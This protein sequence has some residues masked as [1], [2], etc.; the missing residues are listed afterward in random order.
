MK[1]LRDDVPF[2]RIELDAADAAEQ[3]VEC[4]EATAREF[5]ARARA[6]VRSVGNQS[7]RPALM[8][9]RTYIEEKFTEQGTL[10]AWGRTQIGIVDFLSKHLPDMPLDKLDMLGIESCLDVIRKRPLA[11]TR[12]AKGLKPISVKY[13]TNSIKPFRNFIRWLHRSSDWD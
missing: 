13:A 1:Q 4:A 10:T 8:A 9:Y 2:I 5:R 12:S 6:L 7:V 11:V 3:V